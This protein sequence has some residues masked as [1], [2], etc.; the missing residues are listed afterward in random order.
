MERNSNSHLNDIGQHRVVGESGP[1]K[2][3]NPGTPLRHVG[4]TRVSGLW[5]AVV[6]AAIVLAFLLVFI[7]QN[8]ASVTV[9]FLWAQGTLALGVAML[10]AALGGG[11]L[12]ALAATA[13]ILQ[14]RGTARKRGTAQR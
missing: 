7:M 13:R 2:P 12:I 3:E 5:A 8:P 14:L 9:Q 11:L 6:V 4:H 10:F 1:A